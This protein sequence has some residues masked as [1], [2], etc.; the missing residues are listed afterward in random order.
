MTR[1][2]AAHS[3]F[4]PALALS[5]AGCHE[6]PPDPTPADIAQVRLLHASPDAP[7]LDLYAGPSTSR[8]QLVSNNIAYGNATSFQSVGVGSQALMLTRTGASY[9]Q[10]YGAEL[11]LKKG[12]RIDLVAAGEADG[13]LHVVVLHESNIAPDA[14]TV[15]LRVLNASPDAT[16]IGVDL[17]AN[18]SIDLPDL[19][20]LQDS[21][22][23]GV[24]IPS[25]RRQPLDVVAGGGTIGSFT[26]AGLPAGGDALLVLTGYAAKAPREDL[27]LSLLVPG[28]GLVKQDPW[29]YFGN[30]VKLPGS[31]ASLD[32]YSSGQLLVSDLQFGSMVQIPTTSS[33]FEA[34]ACPHGDPPRS[35]S[36]FP[37][38]VVAYPFSFQSGHRYLVLVH[39]KVEDFLST[40]FDD[41]FDISQADAQ[42]RFINS[43]GYCCSTVDVGLVDGGQFTVFND[44]SPVGVLNGAVDSGP[45]LQPGNYTLGFRFTGDTTVFG[46]ETVLSL[47]SRSFAV[48]G[49]SS[50]GTPEP[51]LYLIDTAT[52]PWSLTVHSPLP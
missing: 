34:T 35:S 31:E 27:G 45:V 29:V 14:G 37:I 6:S 2:V 38:G 11:D 18:G 5:I 12:D 47:G 21:G 19:A 43:A 3:R 8:G 52:K 41:T 49:P 28:L 51:Q 40:F 26:L 48:F 20:F 36:C 30:L 22:E 46:F 44:Y 32:V 1:S 13:G 24:E 39:F 17:G 9:D 16:P 50:T 42:L 7:P 33:G 4:L 15:R 10:L 25:A 23:Q